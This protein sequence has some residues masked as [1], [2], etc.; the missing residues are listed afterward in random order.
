MISSSFVGTIAR[1][2]ALNALGSQ[3]A[4][5]SILSPDV[6]LVFHFLLHL[7]CSCV[8][9]FDF[10]LHLAAVLH[11]VAIR[12]G[13][14]RARRLSQVHKS[15][16]DAF[17]APK[18]GMRLACHCN[19]PGFWEVHQLHPIRVIRHIS[20]WESAFE[21]AADKAVGDIMKHQYHR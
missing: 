7:F 19:K 15:C 18:R 21:P 1:N 5:S 16:G 6:R 2:G 12:L 10:C 3:K 17:S 8:I 20:G 4:C 9:V 14:S 13:C 11:D